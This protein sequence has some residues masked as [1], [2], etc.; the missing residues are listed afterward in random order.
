MIK[1]LKNKYLLFIIIF[2][3]YLCIL[4][5]DVKFHDK[6]ITVRKLTFPFLRWRIQNGR[7]SDCKFLFTDH[8]NPQAQIFKINFRMQNGKHQRVNVNAHKVVR[9]N[10]K[11]WYSRIFVK[12][13]RLWLFNSSFWRERVVLNDDWLLQWKLADLTVQNNFRWLSRWKLTDFAV[14]GF[15]HW[16]ISEQ[17]GHWFSQWKFDWF[18]LREFTIFL[19]KG[20][21]KFWE[22]CTEFSKIFL[23]IMELNW[24]FI[25]CILKLPNCNTTVIKFITKLVE[26]FESM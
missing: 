10:V 12:K 22:K 25:K 5:G 1:L 8:Q 9:I 20:I 16:W 14:E 6:N 17:A 23:N 3:I 19:S 15:F 26:T 2:N 11:T 18:R 13:N 7:F 21:L 24:I 4:C